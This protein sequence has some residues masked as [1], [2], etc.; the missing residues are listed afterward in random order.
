MARLPTIAGRALAVGAALAALHAAPA[1]ASSDEAAPT[2][3][4]TSVVGIDPGAAGVTVEFVGD[5]TFVRLTVEP[6]REVI[7]LG[8]QGEPY[9]RF[10][11]D[12]QVAENL[13]A[14]TVFV[15]GPRTPDAAVDGT[16]SPDDPPQWSIVGDG[17]TFVW[18]DHRAHWMGS[19]APSG[20]RRGEVIYSDSIPLLVDGQEVSV[21]LAIVW[22]A[23]ASTWPTVVGVAVVILAVVAMVAG[24]RGLGAS[25]IDT[26]A[27]AG[28][29]ATAIGA[30]AFLSASDVFGRSWG[31]F[32]TPAIA[33]VCAVAA[34]GGSRGS[35]SAR[36]LTLLASLLLVGWA[37]LR[38]DWL[39]RAVLP[40][41]A[42][43]WLDRAV[44]AGAL[45]AGIVGTAWA[46][47]ALV[48]KIL[49]PGTE[50]GASDPSG[51]T[52]PAEDGR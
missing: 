32:V 28:V 44:T 4:E 6:G 12:G 23:R 37:F 14:P 51:T 50:L 42:P 48:G 2:D 20:A 43:W 5:T 24:G 46:G 13:R 30:W 40:T 18:H 26:L 11:A 29:G 45:A 38:R 17:G 8:Y 34:R 7:V 21:E 47:A 35:L 52:R 33:A 9:L 49:S 22:K 27:A 3:Y 19:M 36:A 39:W 41:S 15:N 31:S 10:G 25:L 1:A 16:A